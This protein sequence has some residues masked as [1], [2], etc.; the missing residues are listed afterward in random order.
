MS[1]P[2]MD[3]AFIL[4]VAFASLAGSLHCASMCGGFVAFCSAGAPARLRP[5]AFVMASY[6]LG[7]L[8][9]YGALGAMAGTLGAMTELAGAAAG[10]SDAAAWISGGVMLLWGGIMLL[11]AAGL[12][13]SR[14]RL[15]RALE[16]RL[17]R[18]LA[19]LN[20]RPP[21]LRA[22]LLGL[23]STLLPCG[24]LY[25]F[26]VVAAGSGSALGGLLVMLA[27][28]LGTVPALF[29]VGLAVHGILG[30][31]RRHAALVT[32]LALVLLGA[33]SIVTRANAATLAL[34]SLSKPNAPSCH[35]HAGAR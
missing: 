32:A 25:A 14:F 26:A 9:T 34:E 19:R 1:P 16:E 4:A 23:S 20:E 11:Q 6:N 3:A 10:M 2:Q 33:F 35:G 18:G 5:R 30:R 27:F 31:V 15:P 12:A 21:A 13:R 8:A 24:W 7:R 22:A 17:S 28:W 29:G